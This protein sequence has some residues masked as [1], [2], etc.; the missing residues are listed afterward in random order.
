MPAREPEKAPVSQTGPWTPQ[1][2][3]SADDSTGA[4]GTEAAW[5]GPSPVMPGYEILGLLGR[6]G[7]GVVY[8]ARQRPLNR[9]V[10]LKMILS[11][12]D[13]ADRKELIRFL[14]EA[15]AVAA[16]KHPHVVQVF[17]Y[18]DSEGR[19]F[20]ALEYLAGGSLADRLKFR[21]RLEPKPAARLVAQLA[22]GVQAIHD[23]GIVHRD[24]KPGNVLFDESGEPKIS[25]FG[26]A[27]RDD[28]NDLTARQ[29]IMGTPAYM[30][31]EQATGGTKFVGPAADVYSLGVILYVCLT[32]TKPF[33][34]DDPISLLRK[35]AEEEPERPRR[36]VPGLPRDVELICLK[37]LA[38]APHDRYATA[39]A[40][41]DDLA[42]F[43][44]DEPVSVRPA[45]AIERAVKWSR[46]KPA[47][48]T[49][50]GLAFFSVMIILFGGGAFALW[51]TR[52]Q[53]EANL[54]NDHA[55]ER[56]RNLL[57]LAADARKDYRYAAAEQNLSEAGEL[58]ATFAPD[59]DAAVNQAKAD[60][61]FVRELDEIRMERSTWLPGIDGGDGHF[62]SE[63]APRKYRD[64]FLTRKHDVVANPEATGATVTQSAIRIDLLAALND[65]AI[66]E[67]DAF[68]RDRVLSAVGRADPNSPAAPFRDPAIWQDSSQLLA[69]VAK[70]E[71]TQLSSGDAIAIASIMTKQG[72]DAAPL[73][74]RTMALNP[75]DFLPPY[76]LGMILPAGPAKNPERVGAFRA[77]RAIR[78]DNAAVL[79]ALGHALHGMGDIPGALAVWK[80]AAR[81][82]PR[83]AL[84]HTQLGIGLKD[85]G[86]LPAAIAS[87]K[88]AVRLDAKYFLAHYNL[89]IALKA[90]GDLPGAVASIQEAIRLKPES[91][92]SH[93][94]LGTYYW[95]QD[96]D[97]EAIAAFK[98]AIRLNPKYLYPR[99]NL[100]GVYSRQKKHVEAIAEF[101]EAIR[102]DPKYVSPH[103]G[104][105]HAYLDL[106]QYT[107]AI[108]TFKVANRLDPKSTLPLIGLG[109][110]YHKQEKYAEAIAAHRVAIGIDTNSAA[111]YSCLGDSLR[112]SGELDEAILAYRDAIRLKPMK[113]EYHAELGDALA[114]AALWADAVANYA[115]AVD[116]DPQLASVHN[117]LAWLLSTGPTEIRNGKRAVE[118]AEK[119]VRLTEGNK[120]IYI[121]TQAAAFAE[122][123]DFAKAI[124]SQKRA[125]A[126][127]EYVRELGTE[128][129]KRLA[130]YLRNQ[131]Y[132]DT[133]MQARGHYH[134]GMSFRNRGD[135]ENAI[136]QLQASIQLAPNDLA[137][138]KT[139]EHLLKD[140]AEAGLTLLEHTSATRALGFSS[141][142]SMIVTSD[143]KLVRIWNA[144]TG[145]TSFKLESPSPVARVQYGPN[146]R[147]LSVCNLESVVRLHDSATG[148]LKGLVRSPKGILIDAIFGAAGNRI[149]AL[150]AGGSFFVMEPDGM[151]VKSF[152]AF[153]GKL[154][155]TR[156]AVS[157]DGNRVC[158]GLGIGSEWSGK[159][160]DL[161]SGTPVASWKAGVIYSVAWSPDGKSI[162]SAEADRQLF[163]RDAATGLPRT[164]IPV[165]QSSSTTASAVAYG[166]DSN[167][168]AIVCFNGTVEVWDLGAKKIVFARKLDPTEIG[169][170]AATFSPDGKRLAASAPGIVRIWDL[171]SSIVLPRPNAM[172]GEIAVPSSLRQIIPQT[173]SVLALGFS[174]D[175]ARLVVGDTKVVRVW[176]ART[177]REVFTLNVPG[178]QFRA[179][180][181][182]AGHI[183]SLSNSEFTVRLWDAATGKPLPALPT[184]QG[185]VREAVFS[186]DGK[187]VVCAD[188]TGAFS[189]LDLPSNK[190]TRSA[191][192]FDPKHI[193]NG[194]AISPDGRKVCF[195][196]G[197]SPDWS[198]KV[199][200]LEQNKVVLSTPSQEKPVWSVAW[201]ADGKWIASGGVDQSVK[202]WHAD[203]GKLHKTLAGATKTV[204]RVAIHP[205][206]HRIAATCFD[207]VVRVWEVGTGQVVESFTFENPGI[208]NVVFSPDGQRLAASAPGAVKIWE[209]SGA[210]RP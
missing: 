64:A 104:L 19:P 93:N 14:A 125:L 122:S 197:K 70:I 47:L 101:K 28:R 135:F 119:A 175:S 58:A 88:E 182:T 98:E 44:A 69:L 68:I 202:V 205:D 126:V 179:S 22:Q 113:A 149:V 79:A 178:N 159:I 194:F 171:P 116:L 92:F 184:L 158:V 195:G 17:E 97:G 196:T 185:A 48:A 20:L 181:S 2:V 117:S 132:R 52:K 71:K 37:C 32:G 109:S 23:R 86:D 174:P 100:G 170:G 198:V 73:L 131:P 6:G 87:Y 57:A 53:D 16:V 99:N 143:S 1:T 137:T 24:L 209:L 152:P 49:A 136:A 163:I 25:D 45:G 130:L 59:L 38:K 120:A 78:P 54:K 21:G 94:N 61:S 8:R 144:K 82:D 134:R 9:I 154:S 192:A 168:V 155:V 210:K 199:W 106:E 188:A 85:S 206:N 173:G 36:R 139:L 147:V 4:A 180:Y 18:G 35:V 141:D 140:K 145:N 172:S 129:R 39:Q 133:I 95:A 153:E 81:V 12:R 55:R 162:A 7:M 27:K 33:E 200:D 76:T 56:A 66:L 203:T 50:Y 67:P 60:L 189:V 13:R 187:R 11:D 114:D 5:D 148:K 207:G 43:A 121:D 115:N 84:I 161:S 156:M 62:E 3:V 103:I 165:N 42:R 80:E 150:S 90:S 26:L 142:G 124:E 51:R 102:L 167:T 29:A 164:V 77:S 151:L 191:V 138:R 177:A 46:R 146:G 166:R 118:H 105:G 96:R 83:H 169:P 183:L 190:L 193:L 176:D 111:A 201:S 75:R 40:L 30:S 65:W 31:P 110:V 41:A 112:A 186:P 34:D 157:P 72:L 10:A 123:G 208:G 204:A 108:A 63:Q 74:R 89:S 128:G 127:P 107:E 15:E 160:W 91:A